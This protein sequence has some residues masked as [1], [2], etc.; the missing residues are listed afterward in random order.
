M[1][2]NRNDGEFERGEGAEETGF[3]DAQP[4]KTTLIRI[5]GKAKA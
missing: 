4:G 1:D 5:S 2:I 3:R